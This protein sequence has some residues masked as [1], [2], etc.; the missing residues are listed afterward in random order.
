MSICPIIQGWEPK[1]FQQWPESG[2]K[3]HK[4]TEI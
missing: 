2:E 4:V 3:R 1:S